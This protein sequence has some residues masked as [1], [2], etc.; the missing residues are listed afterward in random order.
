[1][2]VVAKQSFRV[3]TDCKIKST[4]FRVYNF[5]F[6]NYVAMKLYRKKILKSDEDALIHI[7]LI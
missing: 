3:L 6:N 5:Y 1:M 7:F 2:A 4:S